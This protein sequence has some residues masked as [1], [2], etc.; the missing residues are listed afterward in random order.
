MLIRVGM[1][2]G[3]G[4]RKF[5]TKISNNRP[6]SNQ[7]LYARLISKDGRFDARY[8]GRGRFSWS[9]HIHDT[10]KGKNILHWHIESHIPRKFIIISN[11]FYF[12]RH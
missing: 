5:A 4:K 9:R 6:S 12:R 1:H 2:G 10:N 11:L 7:K 8:D 3:I